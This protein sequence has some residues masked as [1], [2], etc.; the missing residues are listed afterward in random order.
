MLPPYT[1]AALISKVTSPPFKVKTQRLY[2]V[3]GRSVSALSVRSDQ[4]FAVF[5]RSATAASLRQQKAYAV[6]NQKGPFNIARVSPRA[7][8]ISATTIDVSLGTPTSGNLLVMH[9]MHRGALTTPAGWT[10]Q[11]ATV[12]ISLSTQLSVLTRIADG[13]ETSTLTLTQAVSDRFIAYVTEISGTVG[14]ITVTS[15]IDNTSELNGTTGPIVLTNGMALLGGV[16]S[17]ASTSTSNPTD[18][19]FAEPAIN[20]YLYRYTYNRLGIAHVEGGGGG[21]SLGGGVDFNNEV[22]SD[23]AWSVTVLEAP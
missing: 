7:H 11:A 15:G 23:H 19:L 14:S 4:L 2:S 8:T 20:S 5:G 18:F 17:V 16:C 6:V 10:L 13:G 21:V 12:A 1:L 3:Y 22:V 9:V